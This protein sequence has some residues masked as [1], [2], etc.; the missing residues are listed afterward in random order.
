MKKTIKVNELKKEIENLVNIA[1]QHL[2][3]GEDNLYEYGYNKAICYVNLIEDMCIDYTK[4][5]YQEQYK[6][7]E[8]WFTEITNNAI[9]K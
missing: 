8:N 2:K 1:I 4:P 7:I 9:C 3:D 5:S 6:E